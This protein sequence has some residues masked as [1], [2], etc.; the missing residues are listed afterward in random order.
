MEISAP[1]APLFVQKKK[2]KKKLNSV[3]WTA[4]ES[5][6]GQASQ[7]WARPCAPSTSDLCVVA[8]SEG[9]YGILSTTLFSQ[10]LYVAFGCIFLCGPLVGIIPATPSSKQYGEIFSIKEEQVDNIYCEEL[11]SQRERGVT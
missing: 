1:P 2:K 5:S 8:G 10:F 11:Q 7:S 3:C 6:R 4:L 9:R